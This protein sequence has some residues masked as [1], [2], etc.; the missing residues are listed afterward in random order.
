[1]TPRAIEANK[2][3]A[4]KAGRPKKTVSKTTQLQQKMRKMLTERAHKKFSNLIDT[5]LNL[6]HNIYIE[7]VNTIK[8]KKGNIKTKRR[9]YKRPP[10]SEAIKYLINQTINK[11]KETH[12][13]NLTNDHRVSIK[14]LEMAAQDKIEKTIASIASED[15]ENEE[16]EGTKYDDE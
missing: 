9:V 16:D 5:Q 15:D 12:D 2:M 3:N 10:S 11:P 7:E 14:Q 1:M 4:K 13:V 6:T 8:D